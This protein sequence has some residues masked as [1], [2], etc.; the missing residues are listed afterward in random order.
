VVRD[1]FTLEA[2]HDRIADILDGGDRR[3]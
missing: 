3:R 2:C 1:R